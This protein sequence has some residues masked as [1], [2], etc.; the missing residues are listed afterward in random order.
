VV[1][2][3]EGADPVAATT[4]ADGEFLLQATGK[5]PA[6]LT[7][8]AV[9]HLAYTELVNPGAP[10][11]DYDLWPGNADAR[12]TAGVSAL[13]EGVA[14]DAAGV[15]VADVDVQWTPAQPPAAALPTGRRVLAG[16][17][18]LLPRSVRTGPDGSF[19][20]ET[21][22]FGPGRLHVAGAPFRGVD[23]T[24]VAGAATNGLRIPQ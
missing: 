4:G 16:G 19:R 20:L 13:L 23:A 21:T 14:V 18:V 6:R 12:V 11:A 24:A 9:G 3:P 17:A 5:Q 8:T 15:P 10:F 22:A 1:W 7:V 2:Q